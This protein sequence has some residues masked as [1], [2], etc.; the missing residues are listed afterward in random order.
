MNERNAVSREAFERAFKLI[1]TDTAEFH[2]D[3]AYAEPKA[4][5]GI[6]LS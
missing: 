2:R 6:G 3:A 5:R 4:T 1:R